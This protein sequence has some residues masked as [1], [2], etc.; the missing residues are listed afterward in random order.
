MKKQQFKTLG[1]PVQ[2][3]VPSTVEEFDQN[4]KKAGACLAEA[5]NNVIYRGSLAELRDLIIH[6]RDAV[7]ASEGQ[8][9]VA[10]FKGMEEVTGIA[11]KT[12]TV[13]RGTGES[14]K[15]VEVYDETE[16]DYIDRVVAEKKVE[17]SS[18]Q[19]LFD[20]AAA[21][22]PFDASATERKPVGPKKLPEKYRNLATE[23]LS[24]AINPATKKPRNLA[25]F[26]V[27]AEKQ[28]GTK[29]EKSGDT[30]K[31]TESL[32]WYLKSFADAQDVF[33]KVG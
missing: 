3:E 23:F 15:D 21:L 14:A 5:T 4:A 11:R 9:A 30:A 2:L 31:D 18:F 16:G 20:A 19:S 12:K 33:S 32:G 6:G 29:W 25:G 22:I 7:P 10:A 8:P 26:V 24:G 1:L 13:K 28:L 17:L 27:A